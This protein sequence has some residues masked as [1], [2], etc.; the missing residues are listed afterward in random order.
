MSRARWRTSSCVSRNFGF[1]DPGWRETLP[2]YFKRNTNSPMKFIKCTML[3][4]N[5]TGNVVSATKKFHVEILLVAWLR[6]LSWEVKIVYLFFFKVTLIVILFAYFWQ[7]ANVVCICHHFRWMSWPFPRAR[8][9]Q[10]IQALFRVS[11]RGVGFRCVGLAQKMFARCQSASNTGTYL[12]S[13]SL[14]VF[15]LFLALSHMNVFFI[16]LARSP[17]F[18]SRL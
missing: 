14:F 12:F 2:P 8:S 6:D 3:L 15:F 11:L 10:L 7:T 4:E 17:R 5:K 16:P 18:G 9:S 1:S 13:F